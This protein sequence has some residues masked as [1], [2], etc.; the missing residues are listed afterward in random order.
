MQKSQ[1]KEFGG[2]SNIEMDLWI[3]EGRKEWDEQRK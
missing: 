3:Q 2:D 1:L